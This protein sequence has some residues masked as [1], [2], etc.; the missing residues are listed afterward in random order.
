MVQAATESNAKA[1]VWP[2]RISDADRCEQMDAV[3]I[4][5]GIIIGSEKAK[6]DCKMGRMTE[7]VMYPV[8]S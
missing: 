3:D 4:I 8:E 7:N 2:I 6:I 5:S 1:G